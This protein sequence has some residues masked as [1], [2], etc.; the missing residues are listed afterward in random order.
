[1]SSTQ[2]SFFITQS[3][4]RSFSR[5]QAIPCLDPN[6]TKDKG[7]S[8][9][10]RKGRRLEKAR[11][12]EQ[13]EHDDAST[14][15]LQ[16][17][18]LTLKRRHDRRLHKPR[19]E[20]FGRMHCYVEFV[21]TP[22]VDTLGTLLVLHF[23]E[24]RYLIGNVSEGTSR[25]MLQRGISPGKIGELLL[26]GRSRWSEI[27]G[28]LGLVLNLAD[29]QKAAAEAKEKS[30]EKKPGPWLTIHGPPNLKYAIATARRFIFRTGMP[31]K[32]LEHG[33][34][35][36]EPACLEPT[37]S[38]NHVKVWAIPILP[39]ESAVQP[40]SIVPSDRIRKRSH[41]EIEVDRGTTG[42]TE[43]ASKV[44]EQM[45]NSNWSMDRLITKPLSDVS[46]PARIF[47]RDENTKETIPYL[48]PLPGGT[49]PVPDIEVLVRQPWPAA[50]TGDLPAGI[51]SEES[52]CYIIKGHDQR[53]KFLPDKAREYN[54][55]PRSKWSELTNGH[56]VKNIHGD[57]IT[58]DMVL[59][60]GRVGNGFAVVDIPSREYIEPL[61]KRSEWKSPKIM[62][63]VIAIFFILGPGVAF[64]PRLIDFQSDMS[65]LKQFISSVDTCVDGLNIEQS[66]ISVARHHR[67]D[68]DSFPK[69]VRDS[70]HLDAKVDQFERVNAD[71]N[72]LRKF[73]Q[74]GLALC[75]EP[76]IELIETRSVAAVDEAAYE[77]QAK[78][79]ISSIYTEDNEI[80]PIANNRKTENDWFSD[81]P[82]AEV[83]I[84]TL[85]TGSSHPS[86]HRNVSGTLLRV[87]G[88]GSYLLD[89]GEGTLGTLR[90]MYTKPQLNDVFK[91]LKM[92][93]ISHLHADH[94]L[95]LTSVIRA[96]YEAVHDAKPSYDKNI[97]QS[98]ASDKSRLAVVSDAPMLAWLREYASIE[99][100]GYSRLLP[101]ATRPSKI[102][103]EDGLKRSRTNLRIPYRASISR[104][105]ARPVESKQDERDTDELSTDESNTD[106]SKSH[107][108]RDRFLKYM[109]LS[110]LEAVFVSHCK[111]AQA[112]SIKTTSGLKVSFSGDCRPS[113]NFA[114]IGKDSDV[115]IH[116]ATFEDDMQ[117]E[118][119]AKKH[120]TS[121]EALIV[122]HQM[123]AKAALL[124]HFSQRYA[125]VPP[126][127]VASGRSSESSLKGLLKVISEE[128]QNKAD[129]DE[130]MVVTDSVPMEVD[131]GS[132]LSD[133]VAQ[134]I[135]E[136]GMAVVMGF[137]YM[138]L[139]LKDFGKI[140][141]KLPAMRALYDYLAR[142]EEERVADAKELTRLEEERKELA[143][144]L[145]RSKSTK[146]MKK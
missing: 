52:L 131:N 103:D 34:S 32:V 109:N 37:F 142:L 63:G 22:S 116:E 29:A 134:L 97:L 136:S 9:G 135:E 140:E 70:R 127:G 133:K 48:G 28:L 36:T 119:I 84:T 101:L 74:V 126:I 72:G 39:L 95:G 141:K 130:T 125:K 21:T 128:D 42:A 143:K 106:E 89:A 17:L 4:S 110:S 12:V 94:H 44:V 85:G 102:L 73:A 19:L 90:R 40:S 99:D 124:T 67:F 86:K 24:K 65:H 78:Q 113:L 16:D 91:D 98:L 53:G 43:Q 132:R 10:K 7:A 60:P 38:D 111:G 115:L 30:K 68:A 77:K 121:G 137:D 83:E 144:E 11:A 100:F 139:K 46:M 58:P 56:S 75:L 122:A 33:A 51:S 81:S 120:S 14:V 104:D 114:A 82:F 80:T 6:I 87:P 25:A 112:V 15:G 41:D 54:V 79:E 129:Q 8:I 47:V 117:G 64:D 118:A 27:G 92:I 107:E 1:M 76:R 57:T 123:N 31:L 108:P 50:V 35:N 62:S 59:E 61:V 146:K 13:T 45:F 71:S 96:W 88:C 145:A 138:R 105:E 26:T 3:G 23:D 18:Y 5:F 69:L 55:V 93:W 20:G 49:E 2:K 66:V